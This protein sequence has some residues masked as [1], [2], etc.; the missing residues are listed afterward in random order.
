MAIQKS[1]QSH[2]VW[3]RAHE[4]WETRRWVLKPGGRAKCLG[5]GNLEAMQG[6]WEST[7]PPELER[8]WSAALNPRASAPRAAL[9]PLLWLLSLCLD[10]LWRKSS[11]AETKQNKTTTTKTNWWSR[12]ISCTVTDVWLML[13]VHLVGLGWK[14]RLTQGSVHKM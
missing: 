1:R 6:S 4:A 10:D 3:S 13:F 11:I 2:K 8:G 14:M 9:L 12:T 5:S 7:Q